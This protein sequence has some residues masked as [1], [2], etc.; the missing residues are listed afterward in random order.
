MAGAIEADRGREA[1][2]VA[3]APPPAGARPLRIDI[4]ALRGVAILLVLLDHARFPYL[5]GGFLGVDI[6]F[7]ISGYLM[8]GMIEDALRAGRFRFADFYARRARRLL[9]AAYATALGTALLSPLLLDSVELD[10]VARQL[11]GSFGF[12]ANI[13]LWRQADYFSAG[14]TLKPL[15]H[16]WSL[17]LEEQYYLAVPVLM[18][19][20]G[21]RWRLAVTVLL[22]LASLGLCLFLLQR[23]PVAAFYLLPTRAW[24]LGIGSIVALLVRGGVVVPGAMRVARAGSLS[25]ILALALFLRHDAAHP[26]I[27][28]L[29]VCLATAV[30]MVPG[31]P[32][33]ALAGSLRPLDWIGDRSYSLYLVHWPLFAFANNVFL[34]EPPAWLNAV[35]LGLAVA[36]AELQYR[37]VEQRYRHVPLTRARIALLIA[38]PLLVLAGIGAANRIGRTQDGRDRI[39]PIG[40][41]AD[42]TSPGE[43]A[44]R[45]GA[46]PATMIWGDSFA[47]AVAGGLAVSTPGGI[48]Q[49]TMATCGPFL[50]IA[51]ANAL[52]PPTWGRRCIDHNRATLDHLRRHPE[53]GTVI[54]SSALA[55][56]V[57]GAE[58]KGWRM[59]VGA[60]DAARVVPQDVGRIAASLRRTVA[61]LR[62]AGKRVVLFAPPPVIDFDAAR[63][64]DRRSAGRPTVSPYPDCSYPATDHA[65]QAAPVRGFLDGMNAGA[66]VPIYDIGPFLCGSGRCVTRMDGVPL[67]RDKAHFSAAGSRLLGRRMDWGRQ[68]QGI[69][70]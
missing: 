8:T 18:L 39:E 43:A 32:M 58:E 66:V 60:G 55:Q 63:C 27:A 17:S 59:L 26:G 31:A 28:A 19:V 44:C 30:L 45:T 7:V 13:V 11:A 57:P 12:F 40:L 22:T 56:Y 24:E 20:A 52:Y 15:L 1:I 16:M 47:M 54:L 42:C 49:S 3:V 67:Y 34:T 35:L 4:Q 37:F 14:A 65:A 48:V 68:L 61:A 33:A 29:A 46:R 36:L 62:A 50:D 6:F 25:L 10:N 41:A 51:P 53:I 64:H 9:P 5:P 2:A 21:R 69:A 70:S 38:V 23:N